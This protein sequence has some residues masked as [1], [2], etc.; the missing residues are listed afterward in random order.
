M[1]LYDD[2][3]P[4]VGK[5]RQGYREGVVLVDIDQTLIHGV[6]SSVTQLKAGDNLYGR[7]ESRQRGEEPRKAVWAS[8]HKIPAVS[9]FIVL[10]SSVLLAEDEHN[11]LAPRAGNYEM[12]SLNASP[13]E[14]EM[15]IAPGVLIANHLE[16][17]GGTAT[18]MTDEEF[19]AQ[20]RI[21]RAWWK[22]K[23]LCH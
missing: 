7:Y 8:G 11:E 21:S 3:V 22:D 16:E 13:L 10:Y 12:I 4:L 14:D 17:D 9:A 2:V 1:E 15:P 23:A 6:R 5:V 18:G 20:L 19:V